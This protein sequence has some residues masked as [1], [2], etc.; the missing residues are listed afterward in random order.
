M[1]KNIHPMA[2]KE[3]SDLMNQFL[4]DVINDYRE[5]EI[6]DWL[7]GLTFKDINEILQR[8]E[9]EQLRQ[10]TF[11]IPFTYLHYA[12]VPN[13]K[14]LGDLL[15]WLNQHAIVPNDNEVLKKTILHF[16]RIFK[17]KSAF[18]YDP[19]SGEHKSY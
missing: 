10:N 15:L 11:I 6:K 3:A 1:D 19:N 4:G 9:H 12:V 14:I 13:P 8:P 5:N 16:N 7:Q 17:G 2:I 18:I